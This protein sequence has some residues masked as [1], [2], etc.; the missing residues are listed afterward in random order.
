MYR[1]RTPVAKI[2][3]LSINVPK[4]ESLLP[5]TNNASRKMD[6]SGSYDVVCSVG[7]KTQNPL[8]SAAQPK[9]LFQTCLLSVELSRPARDSRVLMLVIILVLL[10]QV[11]VVTIAVML[12]G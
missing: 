11:L 8:S 9:R 6:G 4:I 2:G 7:H 3:P 12:V 10:P 1:S 5:S